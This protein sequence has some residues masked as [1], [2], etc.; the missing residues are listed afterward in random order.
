MKAIL[1]DPYA[2][3]IRKIRCNGDYEQISRLI[4]CTLF[5]AVP[6][7]NGDA[8]YVDSERLLTPIAE[9][10]FWAIQKFYPGE[11][12][13]GKGLLL[14][15]DSIGNSIAP[16]MPIEKIKVLVTFLREAPL[17]ETPP[18]GSLA[19]RLIGV[20]RMRAKLSR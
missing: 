4:E 15:S 12:F 10:R 11:L 3:T 6:L 2:T 1:I 19:T 8:I 7:P 13:P 20:A 14:G 9:R 17:Q 16:R 18:D 5:D